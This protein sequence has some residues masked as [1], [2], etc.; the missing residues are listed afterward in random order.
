MAAAGAAG[1][2]RE[3]FLKQAL[4]ARR[5][6]RRAAWP[7]GAGRVVRWPDG[8]EVPPHSLFPS[9]SQPQPPVSQPFQPRP[10]VPLVFPTEAE[11]KAPPALHHLRVSL[12]VIPAQALIGTS[13]LP[14]C[15][16]HA[17]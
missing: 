13:V 3:P 14:P 17:P 9:A 16:S 8:G 10:M 12:R 11:C 7:A 1:Q 5:F 15:G 6:T 2:V 4:Y